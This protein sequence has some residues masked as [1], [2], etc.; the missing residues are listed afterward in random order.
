MFGQAT[1][2][3]ASSLKTARKRF[4]TKLVCQVSLTPYVKLDLYGTKVRVL[5]YGKYPR[6]MGNL[7]KYCYKVN[8][9]QGNFCGPCAKSIDWE[10]VRFHGLQIK[11]EM[12]ITSIE[13][14]DDKGYVAYIRE[15]HEQ[16]F[17]GDYFNFTYTPETMEDVSKVKRYDIPKHIYTQVV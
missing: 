2:Y 10:S 8:T 14:I 17:D 13:I 15:M 12:L 6:T 7:A 4:R 9:L 16:L 3:T 5:G 1:Q 11:T